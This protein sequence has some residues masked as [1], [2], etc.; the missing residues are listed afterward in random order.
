MRGETP[1]LAWPF[2][3]A[4]HE[5]KRVDY[6]PVVAPDFLCEQQRSPILTLLSLP[7]ESSMAL[8]GGSVQYELGAHHHQIFAAYQVL[9]RHDPAF[10]DRQIR[11]LSGLVYLPSNR[12][13]G[14]TKEALTRAHQL[15]EEVYRKF[16]L[17]SEPYATP[18]YASS[19]LTLPSSASEPLTYFPSCDA[20]RFRA[21]PFPSH[22]LSSSSTD[23][24]APPLALRDV[25]RQ[26][27]VAPP[28]RR[29]WRG[30]WVK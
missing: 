29:F 6:R 2:V 28:A 5:L 27:R 18:V 14:I 30:L 22:P 20:S 12:G 8:Y 17:A 13:I 9:D 11:V 26:T 16:C 3:V 15:C 24:S 4:N 25:E 7:E 23:T 1:L 21:Q 19:P 10:G